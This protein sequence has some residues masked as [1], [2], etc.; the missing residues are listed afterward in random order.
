MWCGVVWWWM[1]CWGW[2]WVMIV[3]WSFRSCRGRRCF[4]LLFLR[5]MIRCS[6][7]LWRSVVVLMLFMRSLWLCCWKMIV[8]MGCMILILWLRMVRLIV[9]RVRFFLLFGCCLFCVWGWRW[10]MLVLRISLSVSLVV[11]IMSFKLLIL[12]KW[13]W[14]WLRNVL[15]RWRD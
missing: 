6:I 8:G 9:R 12:L 7:L 13:I 14:R 15:S 10:F 1:F 4:G 2:W 11:F 3:N 5:L